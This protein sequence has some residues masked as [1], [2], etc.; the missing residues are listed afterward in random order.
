MSLNPANHSTRAASFLEA[1]VPERAASAAAGAEFMRIAMDALFIHPNVGPFFARQMI[2]RLVTSNPSPAYVA[3]VAARF[4]NNGAGV[5]GD[6]QAVWTAILLDDEA[7]GP[8]SLADPHRLVARMIA[9]RDV[10]GT[11][12]QV[13]FVS[14]GGFDLH[15]VLINNQTT[16]MGRLSSALTAFH[17]A[18]VS[19]GV[20]DKVTAF[21][22]SDFGRTLQ[23]NGDGSDH[24]WGSH[25]IMVGGAVRAQAFYGAAPSGHHR[26]PC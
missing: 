1:T 6:L 8:N 16:L 11:K 9:A 19:L 23:R 5:R 2:Q 20:A 3:R 26:I 21:T 12:R 7:R 13:F 17:A 10:L 18:T 22:A 24:G 25:H 4:N 15:D 14:M